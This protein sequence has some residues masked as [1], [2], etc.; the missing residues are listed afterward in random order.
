MDTSATAIDKRL[1]TFRERCAALGLALT[2][3][4][5]AI[6]HALAGDDSHP[7]AEEIYREVKPELP[8][9]SLGTV[10][11]TLELLEE[12]GLI[13]RVLTLSPQARYDANQDEHHHFICLRCR[14]VLD[15]QD[16]R[17]QR[18]PIRDAAPSGF[19]VLTHR[20]Q[21]LGLC[22]DCQRQG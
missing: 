6:Y 5:L 14:R 2:P 12:N 4:R 8:S 19:R 7:S 17:L 18:L 11:R 10:Y 13:S 22:Q 9:L 15:S 3:Q 1:S 21:V 16:P 20:L